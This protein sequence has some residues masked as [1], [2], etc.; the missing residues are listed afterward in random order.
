MDVG[1]LYGYRSYDPTNDNGLV[2]VVSSRLEVREYF[3]AGRLSI[4]WKFP[5]PTELHSRILAL[6]TGEV[7]EHGRS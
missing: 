3:Q 2:L 1:R 7:L 6:G 4:T 5:Y